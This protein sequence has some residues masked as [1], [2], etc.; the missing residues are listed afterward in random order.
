MFSRYSYVG[1]LDDFALRHGDTAITTLAD[2]NEKLV[3]AVLF[4]D[5]LVVNDGYVLTHSAVQEALLNPKRSPLKALVERGFVKLLSRNNGKIEKLAEL[6][7]A[8]GITSA[9]ELLQSDFFVK[10]YQPFLTRWSESLNSGAFESM[11]PWPSIRIDDVYRSVAETALAT[12]TM[13]ETIPQTDLE[14]FR[15]RLSDTKARRTEWEDVARA[16]LKCG[17]L[18]VGSYRSLMRAANEI[19]QYTWGCSLLRQLPGVRV[20]TRIPQHLGTLDHTEFELPAVARK[21][22]KVFIPDRAFVVKAVG[23]KWDSLAVMVT[24]GHELNRLKHQFLQALR[25]YYSSETVSRRQVQNASNS[26]T[27][28]LSKH[29]GE[30]AAVPV[31]FDLSFVTAS[32]FAG[33]LVQGLPGAAIGAAVSLVGVGAAHLGAPRLLWRLTAPA[34]EKWLV[35]KRL[36]APEGTTSCF[37]LD[38]ASAYLHTK[39]ATPVAR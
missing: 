21:Q 15:E 5:P 28:A 29:F 24:S 34:P 26:Y 3:L 37:Q 9:Q 19:Y 8:N 12:A 38:P 17:Q 2:L 7:A 35:H 13:R 16:M 4:S 30:H 1:L 33:T 14:A 23:E 6:M 27:V 20:L 39:N 10:R 36:A 18:Q 25:G 22:V 32:T 11:L 31:I